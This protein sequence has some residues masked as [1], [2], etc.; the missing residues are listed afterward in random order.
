MSAALS[1]RNKMGSYGTYILGLGINNFG[2]ANR[3]KAGVE[4]NLNL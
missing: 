1:L 4:I 2:T 3:F